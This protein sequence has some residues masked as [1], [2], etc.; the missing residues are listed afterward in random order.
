MNH[1]HKDEK[2]M[3]SVQSSTEETTVKSVRRAVVDGN[4]RSV[5]THN[6]NGWSDA[7]D[8]LACIQSFHH[9]LLTQTDCLLLVSLASQVSIALTRRLH[10]LE[11]IDS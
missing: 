1:S 11:P 2:I 10:Q 7:V 3:N 6:S 9:T 4:W 5:I 8:G